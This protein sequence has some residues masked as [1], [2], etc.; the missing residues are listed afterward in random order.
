[1][2]EIASRAP[3][4]SSSTRSST[5]RWRR[6]A[7]R[8][9]TS[10]LVAVTQGP[11]LVGA[12]LVGVATAQG[13]RRGAAAAARAGRPPAGPR[14]GELP[15]R[16][17]PIEPPFLCLLA[18]GGH[19]LLAR[20][21]RPGG[22]EMLGRTLDDAAGEAFD[23]GARLLGLAIRAGRR[24]RSWPRDGDPGRSRSRPRRASR[25][26]TSRSRGSRPRCS[27]RCATWGRSE[28]R[29]ARGR[30]RRVL[31][32][33]DRRGADGARASAR[34]RDEAEPRLAIGGGVAAN[35][36]LR[37]RRRRARRRRCTSRRRELCTDNAAMI[38]SAARWVEPA[39]VPALPG[40]RRLRDAR[41]AAA[42][43]DRRVRHG[44]VR[45]R[46]R[47]AR[48]GRRAGGAGRRSGGR[49]RAGARLPPRRSPTRPLRRPLAGDRRPGRASACWSSC[50]GRRW[51][52]CADARDDERRAPSA[53][54]SL[55]QG[56]GG[57]A[58]VGARRPRRRHARRRHVRAASGTAS[59][60]RS[61]HQRPAA[62]AVARRAAARRPA[63][64]SR[65]CGRGDAGAAAAGA[66]PSPAR[67]APGR[68]AGT[69]PALDRRLAGRDRRRRCATCCD[70]R[71]RA[72][73]ADVRVGGLRRATARR[74][75]GVR[76]H[77]RAAATAS[78]ALVDP[79]GDGDHG[80]PRPRSR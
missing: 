65:R 34:W 28:T 30:P 24:S 14:G 6:P 66:P 21:D 31:R 57:G 63:L 1:M 52:S 72:R 60:R 18:S 47:R 35:R 50:R 20:V 13:A 68:R 58:A 49:R 10:T 42:R 78:S 5:T 22:Y 36:L 41:A 45:R 80:R 15:R 53:R 26:S 16:R 73:R 55:A 39:A 27:T 51:A 37:E 19:T 25:A 59:R 79:D 17:T 23:K 46:G 2:P 8:S 29:A 3:P 67:A 9:T 77:G 62:A 40:A 32:A 7:R 38:A 74:A 75:G 64:L 56:R 61:T 54:T 70:R 33:R 44:G 69:A 48:G 71:R 43:W 12:L 4:A 76:P 11:G